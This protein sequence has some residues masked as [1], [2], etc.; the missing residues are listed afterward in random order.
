MRSSSRRLTATLLAA[1]LVFAGACSDD[2]GGD[3]EA[4][5]TTTTEASESGADAPTT[6]TDAVEDTTTTTEGEEEGTTTVP[7]TSGEPVEGSGAPDIEAPNVDW[8]LS[9]TEYRGE[10]GRRIAFLCPPDGEVRSVWGTGTYTDDS[11]VCSAAVHEGLINTAEGG[12]V[13]IEIAPGQ[14]AYDGSEANGVTSSDYGEYGGS[15]TFPPS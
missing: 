13:V 11:S 2:D 15:Y 12:R 1:G 9:A 14:E 6:T 10:D 7:D 4:T 8:A 5:T 3:E